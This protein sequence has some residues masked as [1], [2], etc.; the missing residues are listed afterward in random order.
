MDN[1][2]IALRLDVH[3]TKG[4]MLKSW[5]GFNAD[6]NDVI[7]RDPYKTMYAKDHLEVFIESL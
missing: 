4:Q 5:K 6:I 2:Q 3:D 1:Y 7:N